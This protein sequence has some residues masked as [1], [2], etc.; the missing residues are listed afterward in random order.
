[1]PQNPL[2]NAYSSCSGL[3]PS[4]DYLHRPEHAT[5]EPGLYV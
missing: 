5:D 2:R 4:L 3:S 1:M